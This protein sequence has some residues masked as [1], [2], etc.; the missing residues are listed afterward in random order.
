MENDDQALAAGQVP[1]SGSID[2]L[3]LSPKISFD[4]SA[5]P[6]V[7]KGSDESERDEE[8]SALDAQ[9]LKQSDAAAPEQPEAEVSSFVN[10]ATPTP[11]IH[12]LDADRPND[13]RQTLEKVLEAN[14]QSQRLE[15]AIPAISPSLRDQYEEIHSEVVERVLA[16]TVSSDG[17]VLTVEFTDGTQHMVCCIMAL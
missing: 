10:L 3:S 17:E 9:A 5:D 16:R 1:T 15:I 12:E 6:D 2:D 7:A 8:A 4:F 14:P 13:D 11:S